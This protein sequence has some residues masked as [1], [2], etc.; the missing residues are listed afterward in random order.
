MIISK[1]VII[2]NGHNM[3]LNIIFMTPAV[4]K[5]IKTEKKMFV[6]N[7]LFPYVSAET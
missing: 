4:N 1:S 6:I 7:T 5:I 2:T 3:I